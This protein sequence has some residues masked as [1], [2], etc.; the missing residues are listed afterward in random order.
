MIGQVIEMISAGRAGAD[1]S[2]PKCEPY[3]SVDRACAVIS[4]MI[5]RIRRSAES[6]TIPIWNS[7]GYLR[8]FKHQLCHR[9]PHRVNIPP[10]AHS[11]IG[12]VFFASYLVAIFC[13]Q[14]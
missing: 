12:R 2:G 11:Q 14:C 3:H 10:F 4:R 7:N 1:R 8:Y 13:K 5:T 9:T 6:V